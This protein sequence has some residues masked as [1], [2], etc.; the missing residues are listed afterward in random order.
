M[1]SWVLIFIA[2]MLVGFVIDHLALRSVLNKYD[3]LRK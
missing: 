3:R 2:G 1:D